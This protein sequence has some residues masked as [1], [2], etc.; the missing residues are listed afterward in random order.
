MRK[1][2][3]SIPAKKVIMD[4]FQQNDNIV[5]ILLFFY[6]IE[7]HLERIYESENLNACI[8]S[9]SYKHCSIGNTGSDV[10]TK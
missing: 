2:R 3:E 10:R 9:K 7:N 5:F 1:V 8:D 6:Q 4:N